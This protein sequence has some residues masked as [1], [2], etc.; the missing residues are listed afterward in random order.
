MSEW[1]SGRKSHHSANPPSV[2]RWTILLNKIQKGHEEVSKW[3]ISI[4]L[5]DLPT[6]ELF[7]P[8]SSWFKV[9]YDYT[10]LFVIKTKIM[11]PT[12]LLFIVYKKR[13]PTENHFITIEY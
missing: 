11:V 5:I 12:S 13:C 3:G 4:F 7:W 8:K 1:W 6:V 9:Q 2:T 10:E